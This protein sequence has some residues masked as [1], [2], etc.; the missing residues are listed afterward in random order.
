[1]ENPKRIGKVR[2]GQGRGRALRNPIDQTRPARKAKELK[3]QRNEIDKS[4]IVQKWKMILAILAR[5]VRQ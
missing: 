3:R 5:I 1:V 2:E 4:V